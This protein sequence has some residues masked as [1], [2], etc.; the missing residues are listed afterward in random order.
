MN[1]PSKAS[2][3]VPIRVSQGCLV[4]MGSDEFLAC[5]FQK[6]RVSVLSK[7]LA[8]SSRLKSTSFFVVFRLNMKCPEDSMLI[9]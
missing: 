4:R 9:L 2:P 3:C 6:E 1:A 8:K 7:S 5:L